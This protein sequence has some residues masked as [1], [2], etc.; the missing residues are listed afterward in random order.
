MKTEGYISVNGWSKFQHYK[1]RTPPWLKLHRDL[2]NNYQFR[3]LPDA[4]KAHLVLIWLL[5]SQLDNI[6]PDDPEWIRE[7]INCN[8]KV[9]LNVLIN[10]NFLSRIEGHASIETEAEV[11]IEA[12]KQLEPPPKKKPRGRPKVLQKRFHEFYKIY[13]V[14]KS[15]KRAQGYWERDK[16]DDKFDMIVAAVRHRM[17]NDR[18]WIEGYI[19]HPSTYLNQELFNDEI[20]KENSRRVNGTTTGESPRDRHEQALQ[21]KYGQGNGVHQIDGEVLGQDAGDV[22]GS[23][24]TGLRP[25]RR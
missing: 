18:Q 21:R 7:R 16:L 25:H 4:S 24:G 11:K 9:D 17:L 5:A 12:E 14:H 13:P 22:R 10:N 2:L 23:V 6:V 8:D 19:P 20:S 1:N 3:D 15:A